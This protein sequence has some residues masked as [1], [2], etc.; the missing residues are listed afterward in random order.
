MTVL[1]DQAIWYPGVPSLW[2]VPKLAVHHTNCMI[3][4]MNMVLPP[5]ISDNQPLITTSLPWDPDP[6]RDPTA[7]LSLQG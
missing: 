6:G 2:K 7:G 5:P 4:A 3:L 1:S